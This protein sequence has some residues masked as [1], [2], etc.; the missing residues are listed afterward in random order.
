MAYNCDSFI[1][2]VDETIAWNLLH[3]VL[4]FK[5][6]EKIINDVKWH[7]YAHI[8]L[9][10]HEERN[11]YTRWTFG[12][13]YLEIWP[14]P[15]NNWVTIGSSVWYIHSVPKLFTIKQNN[16]IWRGC[17]VVLMR[18]RRKRFYSSIGVMGDGKAVVHD[19]TYFI[20]CW[21]KQLI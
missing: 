21:K 16:E 3:V 4:I 1:Y 5:A 15:T 12:Y 19:W 18:R 11:M 17:Q 10:E 6:I 13:W 2:F 14:P 9:F 8:T 20:P 7:T